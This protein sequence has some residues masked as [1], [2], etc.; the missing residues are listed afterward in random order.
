MKR[1]VVASCAALLV[2]APVLVLAQNRTPPAGGG[3]SAGT[4][5]PRGGDSGSSSSSSGSSGGGTT[6]GSSGSGGGYFGG[7]SPAGGVSVR[8]Y[9][10][11]RSGDVGGSA[12]ARTS[13]PSV[14]QP[15]PVTERPRGDGPIYGKAVPRSGAPGQNNLVIAGG[16]YWWDNPYYGSYG[17]YGF[18]GYNPY[19]S[20]LYFN[21]FYYDPWTGMSPYFGGMLLFP[22]YMYSMGEGYYSVAPAYTGSPLGS[23]RLHMKPKEAE[24]YVDGTYY[25]KVDNYDG[26]FDHLDL[27][28][29][30]HL[31]EIRAEGFQTIQVSLR[32]LPGTTI[33]YS[34]EMKAITK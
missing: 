22:G 25:G 19:Y 3:T 13:S 18:W 26:R 31:L 21:P 30:A 2:F 16:G 15:V 23:I 7:G 33:T 9:D 11:P 8:S 17:P 5:A 29:G 34:G 27:P 24:V 32:V 6:M 1:L 12:R 14:G 4:A 10:G 20:S 28:A